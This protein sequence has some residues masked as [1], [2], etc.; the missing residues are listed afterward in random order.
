[1]VYFFISLKFGRIMYTDR[2]N[3]LNP[4]YVLNKTEVT[5][6]S[7]APGFPKTVYFDKML[8]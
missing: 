6:L 1:M 3:I 4:K 5:G 7:T 8:K 2:V